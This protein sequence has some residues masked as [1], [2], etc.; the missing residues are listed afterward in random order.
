MHVRPRLLRSV[1]LPLL[2]FDLRRRSG[3]REK[4]ACLD[5]S[6]QLFAMQCNAARACP[7]GMPRRSF[8]SETEKKRNRRHFFFLSSHNGH[9]RSA[10]HSFGPPRNSIVCNPPHNCTFDNKYFSTIDAIIIIIIESKTGHVISS[11]FF[12]FVWLSI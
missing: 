9:C 1:S 5:M 4:L 12:I 11:R 7:I 10:R 6:M 3:R 8:A 2:P